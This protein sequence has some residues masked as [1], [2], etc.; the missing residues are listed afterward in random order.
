MTP[1]EQHLLQYL[2]EYADPP[3]AQPIPVMSLEE[4]FSLPEEATRYLWEGLLPVGG[5][6]ILAAK[7]KVGKSTLARNLIMAVAQGESLL[8]RGTC[9]APV[10]YLAM[11]EKR[12][13]VTDHLRKLRLGGEKVYS[14]FGGVLEDPLKSLALTIQYTQAGLVVIDPMIRLARFRDTNDYTDVSQV[15]EPY[16]QL[17]RNTGCHLMFVHHQGKRGG[18]TDGILGSTAIFGSVDT[19]LVMVDVGEHRQLETVQR[20][21]KALAKTSLA[22]NEATGRLSLGAAPPGGGERMQEVRQAVLEALAEGAMTEEQLRQ[23]VGGR[24]ALLLHA[25]ADA[26]KVGIV[27]RG[28]TGKRGDP[29]C[30]RLP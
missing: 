30:Y 29:Y 12:G 7:P 18:G 6:S 11:E 2:E 9:Q 16:T 24:K 22:Y 1:K 21:G 25:L 19:A 14:W 26:V 20:Y 3:P 15:L 4:L 5:I 28:G 17:A 8:G 10:L 13:E 27:L 23:V